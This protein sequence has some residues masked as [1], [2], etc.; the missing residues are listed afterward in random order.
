MS[1]ATENT[2]RAAVQTAEAV[3]QQSKAAAR[4]TYAFDPANLAAYIV[5]LNDADVAYVT[6]VNTAANT[7]DLPI[8]NIGLS[9]PIPSAPWTPLLT[10][11]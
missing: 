11:A 4:V 6:S 9:G 8:G 1:L 5:A 10:M 3:R 7:L 2:F